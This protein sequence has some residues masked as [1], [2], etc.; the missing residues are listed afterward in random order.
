MEDKNGL[1]VGEEH[2]SYKS[3]IAWWLSALM[4]DIQ[5]QRREDVGNPEEYLGMTLSKNDALC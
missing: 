5:G 4:V 1:V 2:D 3:R